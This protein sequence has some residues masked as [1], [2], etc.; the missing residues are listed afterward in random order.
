[1]LIA[2]YDAIGSIV[3]PMTIGALKRWW[4]PAARIWAAANGAEGD[5]IAAAEALPPRSQRRIQ[6][7]AAR[8]ALQKNES[9][10]QT[11]IEAEAAWRAVVLEGGEGDPAALETSRRRAASRHLAMHGPLAAAVG[12]RGVVPV[13]W[14]MP[15]PGGAPITADRFL[16]PDDLHDVQA[17]PIFREGTLLRQW[18]SARAETDLPGDRAY[19]RASWPAEDPIAGALVVGSG[20]GVEWD[21]FVR[22]RRDY[23]FANGFTEHGLAVVELVSPGHGLRRAV[24][25]YGGESFFQG[26][27]VTAGASLAAQVRE[28]ARWIAWAKQA[29]DRPAGLFGVSMSSFAAQLA[30]THAGRWPEAARPDAAM[31]MAHSGNLMDITQGSLSSALGLPK[32]LQAAG[33]TAAHL[34]PWAG[35]LEPGVVLATPSERIIS[36]TGKLDGVTPFAGGEAVREMWAIPNANR[37]T[38]RHGHMGLPLRAMLDAAAARRLAEVLRAM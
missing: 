32:A 4:F 28:T 9:A 15:A 19:A 16:A 18:I 37:F 33:W 5:A 2:G 26:A 1:M 36:L 7:K 27:P 6:S 24:H 20:V 29:W 22:M 38:Y 31:L 13:A 14:A 30:L 35:A 21:A 11:S 25:L 17:G 12:R 3:D 8:L 23:D 10:R 34:E